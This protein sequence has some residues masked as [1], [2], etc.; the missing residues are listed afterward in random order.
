MTRNV[1]TS[2]DINYPTTNLLQTVNDMDL[3]NTLV[4]VAKI[5]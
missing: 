1:R 2:R 5:F 4:K 3:P